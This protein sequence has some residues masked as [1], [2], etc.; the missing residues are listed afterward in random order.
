M[1]DPVTVLKYPSIVAFL[2]VS[3]GFNS[4]LAPTP[5]AVMVCT[6]LIASLP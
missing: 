4:V 1:V 6:A 5:A 3:T 2:P